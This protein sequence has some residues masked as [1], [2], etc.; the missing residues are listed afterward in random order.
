LYA[1]YVVVTASTELKGKGL[2]KHAN[3]TDMRHIMQSIFSPAARP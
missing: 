1:D 2:M 3:I